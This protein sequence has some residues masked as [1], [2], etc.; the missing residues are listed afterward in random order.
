MTDRDPLARVIETHLRHVR[1]SRGYADT[2]DQI[3]VALRQSFPVEAEAADRI[4][5]ARRVLNDNSWSAPGSIWKVDQILA[6]AA[7]VHDRRP[8][9][10]RGSV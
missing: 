5:E 4:R 1:D 10:I 7:P 9:A 8:L 6:G 3:A 2:A